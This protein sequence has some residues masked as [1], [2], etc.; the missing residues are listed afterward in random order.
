LAAPKLSF[1]AITRATPYVFPLAFDSVLGIFAQ[2][3]EPVHYC[4]RD[5]LYAR[6]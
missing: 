4:K 3:L 5:N 6:A 2:P 1:P